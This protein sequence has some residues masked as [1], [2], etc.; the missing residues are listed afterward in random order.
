LPKRG[1]G[2]VPEGQDEHRHRLLERHL[3]LPDK[4]VFSIPVII[5]T[6]RIRHVENHSGAFRETTV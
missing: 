5:T 2:E 1:N 6:D 4:E 3:L